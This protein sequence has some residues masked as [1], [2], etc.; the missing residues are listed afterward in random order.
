MT[1]TSVTPT[2][3][4]L[5]GP[6]PSG[7]TLLEA[8][9]GTG[10]T[11]AIAALV[12]RY[13]AQGTPLERLLV[14]TFTRMA[15]GELRER[16][17]ERLVTTTEALS[18]RLAGGTVDRTDE[19]VRVLA[20]GS[21]HDVALRA[22]RL[23]K[24]VADFDAA[25]IETTHGFCL[26][27]L[28]GLGMAG[29]VERDVTFVE[30]VRDLLD[31]V[32][33]DL[34]IRRFWA[35]S[36]PPPFPRQMAV[37][38]GRNV[39]ANPSAAILPTLSA[40]RSIPA[41]RRR[42]A[43]VIG[44]EMERRKR[45]A[46]LITFDDLLTRLDHALADDERGPAVAR[47]LRGRYDVAL[48]DEFQDT[49]LVQWDIM[50][51]AFGTGESTLV[52]IGDPKQA[53]Y[54]FRGADVFSYLDAAATAAN[55]ATL[56][57]NWRSDQGLIDAY[58][59]LFAGSQLGHS[60]IAYRKVMAAAPNAAPR[61]IGVTGAPLRVRVVDR[62]DA[63]LT[64]KGY[65]LL[66][67][68]RDLVA[69]DVAAEVATLLESRAE[70]LQ[71]QG[72]P[73]GMR[74]GHVAV[75]VRTN[76]QA[77]SICAALLEAGVPA[78]TNGSGS[79]F[80]TGPAA[81][82]LRLLE[83]LERPTGRDRAASAALTAFIGWTAEQVAKASD[84]EWEDL[85]W[86]LHQWAAIFRRSGVSALLEHA[87]ATR[88]IPE[89]LLSRTSGERD[90]TDL[91]HVGQLLHAA[92]RTEGLGSTAITSWLHRRIDEAAQDTGDE[93]RSRRL[94]SDAEAVQVLTI[95]R[96]KGL[97]FPVVFCPY[98]WDFPS[99]KPQI[100]MFHDPDNG[101]AR[102]ID[103]GGE[104]G[105]GFDEHCSSHLVEERGEDVRLLY[106][107]LTRARHQAVLWW[108]GTWQGRDA[109]LSRL[110]FDRDA[111]GVVSSEGSDTPSDAKA[112][113]RFEA[114][115]AASGGQISV[116]SVIAGVKKR[117]AGTFRPSPILSTGVFDRTLDERWRRTSYSGI[118]SASHEARVGSE[119]EE[120]VI[121]DEGVVGPVA[122]ANEGQGAE[123]SLRDVALP[124]ATLPGG[125]HV[126]TLIHRVLEATDFSAED[127]EVELRERLAAELAWRP[128]ELGD[129]DAW[130]AG[131][132]AMI[133]TPLGPLVDEMALHDFGQGDRL[134]EMNFELPLVGGDAPTGKLSLS[135]LAQMLREQLPP[136][137]VLAGYVGRLEDPSLN[138]T[139]RGYLSGSLDL[140]LRLPGDRF[141]IVDYKTNYLGAAENTIP[142]AWHYRHAALNAEMYQAHYPLQALLYSVAL[143]R[144]LRWRL[145]AYD[146]TRQ[147]AGVLYLFVRGMSSPDFPRIG[148]LPCGVWGWRPPTGLVEKLS[149]LFDQGGKE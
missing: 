145:P 62:N 113:S 136:D 115:A 119:P 48:V 72:P 106:V 139:L 73:E 103:V 50:R 52:L 92:A 53:I 79:V 142:N 22:E 90:L 121:N 28:V 42:L 120:D 1:P 110:V 69:T 124:L 86:L 67:P 74:P 114:I 109:P 8:S 70:V 65:A 13:V 44:D 98:L 77:L 129:S 36:A 43:A 58:D 146:P 24:A 102:T 123:E 107:A 46:R 18:N 4:D 27:V 71:P 7:V 104:M 127:P 137:D 11:F 75:L 134:D 118:T 105:Q 23:A 19:V 83:A 47:W 82:W 34:Y 148:D 135:N 3:F 112:I 91:R 45:E 125:V 64:S 41:M 49:D 84:A 88:R 87:S 15:T 144:Y 55:H 143:H 89:R 57:T 20:D 100:P 56:V 39:L 147:F 76:V 26:H 140:V 138:Q 31:E 40:A 16:V 101:D 96:S 117:W 54:A 131:L 81:D 93:E 126:G 68:A 25:T 141:A 111:D 122:V 32:V 97:E 85:H 5:A 130:V 94:E 51:R 37:D 95:H 17:R 2:P 33:D 29:D 6:L 149:D 12:A 132:C 10:K 66:N 30:E 9:A 59:A 14:I 38:I 60:G 133:A 99:R 61:L 63:G 21:R 128:T 116:E 78:V 108:A 80:A 35:D